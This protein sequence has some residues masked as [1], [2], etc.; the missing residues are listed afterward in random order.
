MARS[1]DWVRFTQEIEPELNEWI[2][3]EIMAKFAAQDIS[4]SKVKAV[5]K[6]LWWAKKIYESGRPIEITVESNGD[7]GERMAKIEGTPGEGREGASTRPGDGSGS[8]DSGVREVAVVHNGAA[9]AD[10]A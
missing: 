6:L 4:L 5:R 10:V 9:V 7:E 2:E 8:H 3:E 1:G